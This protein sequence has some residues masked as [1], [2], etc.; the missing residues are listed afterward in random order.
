MSVGLPGSGIGGVF[1]LLSAMWMPAH[2]AQRAVRGKNTRYRLMLRQTVLATLI[3]AA[4]WGTGYVIDMMLTASATSASLRAAVG[5]DG[6]TSLPSIFRAASFA[7][8]FGTLALVL[9]TV[10]VLRFV[11]P[12]RR[13]AV[14]P[15][16]ADDEPRR[17]AA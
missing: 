13:A 4:L 15:P 8:T 2:S 11:V 14:A 16:D 1:Y 7:M 12:R 10:Q 5:K 17:K 3:I 9:L 6:G